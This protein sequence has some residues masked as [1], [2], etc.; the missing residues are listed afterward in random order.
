M[1][2]VQRKREVSTERYGLSGHN[3]HSLKTVHSDSYQIGSVHIVRVLE[4][5]FLTYRGQLHE[6]L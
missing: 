4:G 1:H 3:F 2:S 6:Y 5:E